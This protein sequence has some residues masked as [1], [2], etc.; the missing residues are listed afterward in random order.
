MC[1]EV[2]QAT[3]LTLTVNRRLA[4]SLQLTYA[5]DQRREGHRVWLSA[6]ILPYASWLERAYHEIRDRSPTQAPPPLEPHQERV[7]W[8]RAVRDDSERTSLREA[9]QPVPAARL[10][11]SANE[12]LTNYCVAGEHL[13][14]ET[15]PEF[16]AFKRWRHAV[17]G[18]ARQIR[19]LLPS[20]LTQAVIAGIEQGLVRLPARVLMAGFDR[21]TPS[22]Q[23]LCQSLMKHGVTVEHD[24]LTSTVTHVRRVALPSAQEELIA[25]ARWARGNLQ[26]Q[27]TRHVAV[28]VPD[29]E[30]RR[31]LVW[32]VFEDVLR[33][34]WY[35]HG[36]DD[37]RHFDLSLGEALIKTSMARA[38]LAVLGA[39]SGEMSAEE[40]SI[41]LTSDALLPGEAECVARVR[42]DAWLRERGETRIRTRRLAQL[43]RNRA[44]TGTRGGAPRLAACLDRWSRQ[45]ISRRRASVSQWADQLDEWLNEVAW[46]GT[47]AESALGF[48][49]GEAIRRVFDAWA[50]LD[51]VL[52]ALP[53]REATRELRSMLEETVYQP[54]PDPPAP[55]QVLGA[56]EAVGL[57]FDGL[58]VCG[59]HDMAWPAPAEPHPL[60][61]LALQ[62]AYDMPGASRAS[63]LRRAER[64]AGRWLMAADR[65]IV[66][67]PRYD[68][69]I[70][71][72]P[73]GVFAHIPQVDVD[74]LEFDGPRSCAESIA[75]VAASL[76]Q[77]EDSQTLPLHFGAKV[78]GGAAAL[79]DQAACPFRAVVRHRF[80]AEDVARP[81]SPIDARM[82]GRMVHRLLERI[83]AQLLCRDA[84]QAMTDDERHAV[85]ESCVTGVL[86]EAQ[87]ERPNTMRRGLRSVE[88]LRLAR[89]AEAWLALEAHRSDF[90]VAATE[91]RQRIDLAGLRFDVVMDRM[92]RLADGRMVLIDYKTGEANVE[93]WM[94]DR[95]DEPQLPLYAQRFLFPQS[96]E[97]GLA[98]VA[99]AR[100]RSGDCA[101]IGLGEHSGIEA[102]DTRKRTKG[103][104]SIQSL[105]ERAAEWAV[106]VD[107]LADE[108]RRGESRVDPKR[109]AE[110]CRYCPYSAL[111]RISD[112]D[113]PS[114]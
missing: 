105:D 77:V 110:T 55:I 63:E 80:G 75:G 10:A 54:A 113:T 45:S 30:Q 31:S 68:V 103:V 33:P 73:S 9:L 24:E 101:F 47:S 76:L 37:A 97:T 100:V 21:I 50:R 109:G 58:W 17:F 65:V 56:L 13:A 92:D 83:W 84:L 87:R 51:S 53:L 4:R 22:T 38:V 41:V 11:C 79:K 85:I 91:Q 12:L 61:P 34:D 40:A 29:L 94:G 96:G 27:S 74:E 86:D 6:D 19:R 60:L 20:E 7:L 81:K 78:R 23:A 67:H 43:A 108:L 59:M 82:R 104:A 90:E 64:I 112:R 72:R 99:F 49:I 111:C 46:P 44:A 95:P 62:R 71:L 14:L 25:A 69:D 70:A 102:I 5:R 42:L 66:S 106:V 88:A 3:Q 28:L 1:R 36:G 35:H 93:Q 98:G 32:D 52:G 57:E 48:R 107:A 26:A 39:L 8:Q 2:T 15:T 16:A 114:Q 89:L 18:H